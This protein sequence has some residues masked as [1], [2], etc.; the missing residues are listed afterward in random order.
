LTAIGAAISLGGCSVVDEGLWPVVMGEDPEP[1]RI[2][3][4]QEALP[5]ASPAVPAEEI[6][7]EVPI[8]STQTREVDALPG[9]QK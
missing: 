3:R 2:T 1:I 9:H 4:T 5:A 6:R 7:S 8:A